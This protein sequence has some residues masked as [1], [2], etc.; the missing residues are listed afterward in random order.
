M[1]N[2]PHTN[3]PPHLLWLMRHGVL[4]LPAV[5]VLL[6]ALSLAVR[7]CFAPAATSWLA[8]AAEA[9]AVAALG[10]VPA[11]L[12]LLFLGQAARRIE[13][14]CESL[15]DS[16]ARLRQDLSGFAAQISASIGAST[17][18]NRSHLNSVIQDTEG[19]SGE[20]VSSL[21]A[22]D[23][24]VGSLL[25]EM[26][27]FISQTSTT[28]SDSNQVLASNST[29]VASIERHLLS[30]EG[31]LAQ[32]QARL[33]TIV[34]T[35]GQLAELVTHIRDISDQTNLLALNAAIEAA[36]AGEAG[37][38]FAVVADEVRRLSSTVDATATRIGNGMKDMEKLINAEFSQRAARAE[39]T[40]ENDRL[41][42]LRGQLVTLEELMRAIQEQVTVTIHSLRERGGSIETLVMNAT[43]AVQFQDITRQKIEQ[44][45]S[46][47]EA[48]SSGMEAVERRSTEPDF[49]PDQIQA[50]LY[51]AESAFNSYVMEDQRRT[52]EAET[53]ARQSGQA[54]LAAVELF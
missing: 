52:H 16:H 47:L 17:R 20:I 50:M 44:V 21:L 37:R 51:D 5:C 15:S 1:N 19:A 8:M 30:R 28:L 35:V 22:I 6:F 3:A 40:E 26:D 34:D 31:A 33:K 13:P 24:G 25:Q 23:G 46:I 2:R 4:C 54:G 14:L 53:G 18:L 43:G 38:G 29:L 45:I 48:L 36:R 49:C 7:W 42:A 39:V 11:G 32:E 9:L 12:G 10:T 41:N 27:S